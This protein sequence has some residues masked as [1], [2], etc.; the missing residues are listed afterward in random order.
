MQLDTNVNSVV[1]Q[2]SYIVK[3]KFFKKIDF[4]L[5]NTVYDYSV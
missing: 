2:L 1:Y 3:Q 4:F 5:T